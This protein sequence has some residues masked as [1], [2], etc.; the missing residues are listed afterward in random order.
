MFRTILVL[1][2]IVF[3]AGT[4]GAV[5]PILWRDDT[6]E[7]FAK[8]EP[9]GVSLTR[10]GWRKLLLCPGVGQIHCTRSEVEE[11]HTGYGESGEHPSVTEIR[12]PGNA[13]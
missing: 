8:G 2:T 4:A 11:S 7:A 13:P 3:W 10:D 9:E 12:P 6:P 5:E 1:S